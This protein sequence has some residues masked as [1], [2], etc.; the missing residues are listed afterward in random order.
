MAR[1]AEAQRWEN[2][3]VKELRRRQSVITADKRI[4]TFFNN[5][6]DRKQPGRIVSFGLFSYEL[7][8]GVTEQHFTKIAT[9]C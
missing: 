6:N 5:F 2:R 3:P 7:P 1:L 8:I 9:S 4:L